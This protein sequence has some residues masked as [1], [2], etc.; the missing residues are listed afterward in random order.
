LELN[1]LISE[2]RE[3]SLRADVFGVLISNQGEKL[4]YLCAGKKGTKIQK[5]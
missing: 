2:E 5:P 4:I 3:K 1:Y